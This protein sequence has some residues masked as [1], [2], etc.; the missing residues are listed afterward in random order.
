MY[1][2]P[3]I[4]R[5]LLLCLAVLC[6]APVVKAQLFYINKHKKQVHL[7]F[8]LVRDMI[9]VPVYINQKGP[10]NFI[11]DSGVGLI[12]ITDPKLLDSAKIYNKRIIKIYGAAGNTESFEAYA[13]STIDLALPGGVS[14]SLVSA[15]VFKED[16]FGLSN[17]AG[18][19]IHGI[20]GYEFFSHLSVKI[21]F[22]DTIL[23]IARSGYYRPFK[24]KRGVTIPLSVEERKPYIKATVALPNKQ[25]TENKFLV[26]LGAGHPLSIEQP[27]IHQAHFNN[28]VK[29]NLGVGLT[30]Q[31]ISGFISRVNEFNLDRYRFTN[32][33]ASFPEVKG[34]RY[35]VPRDGNLGLGILKRF[36]VIMD[37]ANSVMYLKPN[38]K[39]NE[40]FEHDMSGMEYYAAGA[41][42]NRIVISRVEPGSAADE[43]GIMANDEITTVNFKRVDKMS[44]V[45]I[46][47]LFKSKD[48]RNIL[49]EIRRGKKYETFVLTLKRRI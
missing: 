1:P 20:L 34:T 40:P 2:F 15:A 27:D 36:M 11:V 10:F 30:G 26:D 32:V 23:S 31:P 7:R 46:D 18:I 43:A 41:E 8:K 16:N 24:K 13:T 48:K 5:Y 9:V 35:L 37:Y 17:Y 39:Y 38:Y 45:D 49:V 28:S 33:I 25:I 19:P 4:K 14:S 3:H 6:F 44:M 42:L 29:A 47:N 22:T 21:N 12:I